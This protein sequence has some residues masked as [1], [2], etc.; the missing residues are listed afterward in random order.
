M[1]VDIDRLEPAGPPAALIE[2]IAA[3]NFGGGQFDFSRN[4]TLVYLTGN[5]IE[6]KRK[7]V[8]ID[9]AGKTQPFFAPPAHFNGPVLSPDGKRLAIAIG[10]TGGID[11]WVYDLEREI[12]TKLPTGGNVV[13]GPVWARDGKH[14]V[15]GTQPSSNSGVMWIRADGGGEPKQLTRDDTHRG[16]IVTSV[17]PDGRFVLINGPG[18]GAQS[19]T[20]DT[21]DP[22]N[23]KAGAPEPLLSTSTIGHGAIS[24]DGRWLA[25]TSRASGTSQVLVRP[26]ANGKIAGS[27]V[28]TISAAGGAYAVWSPAVAARRLLY[29]TSEGRIMVVDYTVEGDSFNVLKSRLWTDKQI[30]T[31]PGTAPRGTLDLR[32]GANGI[33]RLFD[34][35]PDGK[36]IIA[37]EPQEEPKEVKVNLHV[38]MLQNWFDELRRRLPPSGK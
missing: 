32:Q 27:A 11:L 18:T 37:W 2:G 3:S 38:T 6:G 20:I 28:W 30:L 29:A 17:S 25:Y 5:P 36:R 24:P 15:Y 34:L 7:L 21:T 4:G 1:A 19:L 14:L 10:A 33:N 12:P 22:D 26:F 16:Q 23:P 9:A 31:I 8:W 35:T 13:L